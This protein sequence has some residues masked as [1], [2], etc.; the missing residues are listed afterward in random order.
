MLDIASNDNTLLR[1]YPKEFTKI[2]IDPSS[3]AARQTDK[4]ITVINTTFP[5][6][7]VN[8]IIEDGSADI[9]TSIACYYDIDDPVNFAKEIKRLLSKK[10]V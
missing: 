10:V 6:Y 7:Q 8:N 3:I 4:D 5:S 1:N 2:G 9:V